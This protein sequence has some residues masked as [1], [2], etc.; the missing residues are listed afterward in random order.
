[1]SRFREFHIVSSEVLMQLFLFIDQIEEVSGD[2]NGKKVYELMNYEI[3]TGSFD[4]KLYTNK[5]SHYD[6]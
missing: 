5:N 2:K 1:M 4:K 3:C 6:Q